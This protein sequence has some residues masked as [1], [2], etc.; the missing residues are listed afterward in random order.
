MESNT[1]LMMPNTNLIENEDEIPM[2][3]RNRRITMPPFRTSRDYMMRVLPLLPADP[4]SSDSNADSN[5]DSDSS[6]VSTFV[7]PGWNNLGA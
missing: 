4:T 3:I 5:S 6:A 1:N 2:W 7:H